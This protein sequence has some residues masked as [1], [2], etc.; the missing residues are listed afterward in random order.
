HLAINFQLRPGSAHER[1]LVSD[2]P[3]GINT[4]EFAVSGSVSQVQIRNLPLNG[5]NFLDLARLEPGVS[6]VS[7]S[8]PGAFANNYS[9]VSIAITTLP[10]IPAYAEIRK[11]RTLFLHESSP[12]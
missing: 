7:V 2:Q 1:V 11:I 12:V 6:V 9:R 3:S 5:R 10:A 4:S 8:N